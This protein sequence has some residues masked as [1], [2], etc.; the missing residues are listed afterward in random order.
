MNKNIVP[1]L[2]K[3]LIEFEI[4]PRQQNTEPWKWVMD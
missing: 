3:C 4:N 1:K 2:E